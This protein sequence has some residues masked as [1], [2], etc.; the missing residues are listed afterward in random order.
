M[1]NGFISKTNRFDYLEGNPIPG[2]GT[3][4]K[5]DKIKNNSEYPSKEFRTHDTEPRIVKKNK[6][7]GPG[8]Y[9]YTYKNYNDKKQSS[10][11]KSN[12]EKCV[13]ENANIPGPGEYTKEY[14]PPLRNHSLNTKTNAV[15]KSETVRNKYPKFVTPGPGYYNPKSKIKYGQDVILSSS[16]MPTK[17][18]RINLA[19][20]DY[21]VG[22]G[23]YNTYY[24]EDLKEAIKLPMAKAEF[25]S[26][27]ER[28]GLDKSRCRVV[29]PGPAFYS[30]PNPV[31]HQSFILNQKKLW[32]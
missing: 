3:Y 13:V 2:P 26:S 19:N 15:F 11:F 24:Y 29:A 22:P 23:S 27:T 4:L 5:L 8:S 1:G 14:F 25:I 7:P 10:T 31:D 21:P 32:L 16:F 20:T 30:T 12:T 6:I 17:N 28:S 9:D 18:D